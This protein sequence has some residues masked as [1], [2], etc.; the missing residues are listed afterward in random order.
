MTYCYIVTNIMC[1][2]NKKHFLAAE[3][4]KIKTN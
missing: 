2:A 4:I 1:R 3:Y